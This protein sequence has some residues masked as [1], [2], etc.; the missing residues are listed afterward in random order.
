MD[1]NPLFSVKRKQ[2]VTNKIRNTSLVPVK[3]L[4]FTTHVISYWVKKMLF[5]KRDK[6]EKYPS[7]L[8]SNSI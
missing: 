7:E 3:S 5:A 8:V 4:K 2:E 1:Q 6:Y